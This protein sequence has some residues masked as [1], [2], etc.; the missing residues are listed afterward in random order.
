MSGELRPVLGRFY[1]A[2]D[3]GEFVKVVS[4]FMDGR[5]TVLRANGERTANYPAYLLRSVV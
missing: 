2:L 1:Y 4:R 5:G 3:Y